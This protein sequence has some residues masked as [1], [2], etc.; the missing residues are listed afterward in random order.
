MADSA[1]L[2]VTGQ[3]S[4]YYLPTDGGIDRREHPVIRRMG[5]TVMFWTVDFQDW[6]ANKASTIIRNVEQAAGPGSVVLF[7]DGIRQSYLR[8]KLC[9]LLFNISCRRLHIPHAL[10]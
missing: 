7:H 10:M 5:H 4:V 2:H 8:G 9:Q 1:I 3:K 6:K